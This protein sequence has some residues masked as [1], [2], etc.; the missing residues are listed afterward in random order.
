VVALELVDNIVLPFPEKNISI[1]ATSEES[2]V[3]W[4]LITKAQLHEAQI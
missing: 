3:S 1:E 4:F 2:F